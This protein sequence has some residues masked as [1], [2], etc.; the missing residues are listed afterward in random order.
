M[1]INPN[2]KI[3]NI[4]KKLDIKPIQIIKVQKSIYKYI[5]GVIFYYGK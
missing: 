4:S 2:Q 5:I 3:M 1:T